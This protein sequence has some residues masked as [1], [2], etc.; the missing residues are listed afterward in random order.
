MDEVAEP[1]SAN[2]RRHALGAIS[3]LGGTHGIHGCTKYVKRFCVDVRV[4]VTQM[5]EQEH[6]GVVVVYSRRT[7]TCARLWSITD[8]VGDEDNYGHEMA[9]F[10]N[11]DDVLKPGQRNGAGILNFC[12]AIAKPATVVCKSTFHARCMYSV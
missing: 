4:H 9:M 8:A 6:G 10:L 12:S 1:A 2:T 3:A 5:Y 7:C 11:M